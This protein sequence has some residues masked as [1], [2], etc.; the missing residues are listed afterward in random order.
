[1]QMP[2]R[3]MKGHDYLMWLFNV[4][5]EWIMVILLGLVTHKKDN[6]ILQFPVTVPF[7]L[8]QVS[9]QINWLHPNHPSQY[10]PLFSFDDWITVTMLIN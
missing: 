10:L 2:I 8:Y 5:D 7:E 4:A 3:L 9:I 6:V 1:M